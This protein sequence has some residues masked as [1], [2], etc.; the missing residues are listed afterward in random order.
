MLSTVIFA[1]LVF[2]GVQQ[3]EVV[4]GWRL[5]PQVKPIGTRWSSAASKLQPLHMSS[6][7]DPAFRD[8]LRNV[9]IIGKL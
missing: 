8:D 2:F 4:E 6:N 1:L 7:I 5:L 3:G 9:A